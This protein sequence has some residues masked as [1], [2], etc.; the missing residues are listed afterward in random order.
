MKFIRV[1]RDK[2]VTYDNSRL[3]IDQLA[4]Y[5]GT[6]DGARAVVLPRV[7]VAKD[8]EDPTSAQRGCKTGGARELLRA[9][10]NLP[11]LF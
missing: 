11:A 3:L 1:L 9:Y 10:H 5:V 6:I 7:P 2:N 4:M 8:D